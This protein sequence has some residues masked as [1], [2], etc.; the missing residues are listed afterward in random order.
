MQRYF[1]KTIGDAQPGPVDRD[2][3]YRRLTFPRGADQPVRRPYTA[4]NMVCTADGKVMVGGPGTTRL[5]GSET[6]HL[7]MSRIELQADAVL[8]GA[9]LVREDDPPYPRLLPERQRQRESMGLR[10]QPLWAV[11]TGSGQFPRLPKMLEEGGTSNTAVFT[12]DRVSPGRREELG[13]N[14]RV[15]VCGLNDVDVLQ[16]GAIL[17]DQLGVGSMIC[18][19]GPTLNATLIEGGEADELFVTLAPKLQG[20]SR[21]PT[22][23]EGRGYP[24][25]GL[26]LLELVSLYGDG[27]ELYLRYRLPREAL[28]YTRDVG[29]RRAR[30]SAG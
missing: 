24:A 16:M 8:L 29:I 6:D 23:I 10:P 1:D 2:E 12:T 14:A 13:K 17:R 22:A 19:G 30:S 27:S 3:V 21:M 28:W 5:I 4:I 15:Y 26:P 20:G 25:T 18:L 7:L 11:V 9:G